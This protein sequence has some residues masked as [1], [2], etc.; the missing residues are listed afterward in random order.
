MS[1]KKATMR[2]QMHLFS[3][4]FGIVKMQFFLCANPIQPLL[5]PPFL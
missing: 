5:F 1:I 2:F 3:I 4:G